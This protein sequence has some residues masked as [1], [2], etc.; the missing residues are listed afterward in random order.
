MRVVQAAI[1]GAGIERDIGN[2]EGAQRI[3]D[4]VAAEARRIGAG[5]DRPFEGAGRDSGGFAGARGG[6]AGRIG[7]RHPCFLVLGTGSGSRAACWIGADPI[8][9]RALTQPGEQP[10]RRHSRR[11]ARC[12]P[13]AGNRCTASMVS[14]PTRPSVPPVSKPS[15]VRRRWISWTSASVGAR[16]L[17]GN[18]CTKGPPPM[19]R[20]PRCTIDERVVHRRV[21]ACARHRSSVRAGRPGRPGTGTHSRAVASGCG[22]AAPSART[23]PSARHAA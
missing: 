22:K 17:P 14:L 11:P 7:R 10:R 1:A 16:S 2:V 9:S 13:C 12:R 6:G 8:R 19:T 20:S 4:D 5:R 3:G 18:G 23:T 15:A 21:V